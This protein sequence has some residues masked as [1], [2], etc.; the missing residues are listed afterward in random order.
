MHW[1]LKR[2]VLWPFKRTK[3][4]E[5]WQSGTNVLPSCV[6]AVNTSSLFLTLQLKV[7]LQ[8]S[9]KK[10]V[11]FH[12]QTEKWLYKWSLVELTVFGTPQTCMS[13]CKICSLNIYKSAKVN[14]FLYNLV[15]VGLF[16][17][18]LTFLCNRQRSS[19]VN[20][21]HWRPCVEV[22]TSLAKTNLL[23]RTERLHRIAAT[24]EACYC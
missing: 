9:C 17:V 24:P 8:K 12:W 14:M 23:F 18:F 20:I 22:I 6:V 19:I 5:H 21:N 2:I 15:C 13:S 11:L 10:N 4:T 3:S 1:Q 16:F 7:T